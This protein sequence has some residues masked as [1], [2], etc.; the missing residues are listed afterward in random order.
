MKQINHENEL[1]R[2][3]PSPALVIKQTS[4]YLHNYLQ[5]YQDYKRIS[6]NEFP[7]D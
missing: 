7:E 4:R 2:P 1:P 5:N 3:A 6:P